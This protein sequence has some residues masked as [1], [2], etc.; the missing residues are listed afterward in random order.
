MKKLLAM[1]LLS[2]GFLAGCNA[3]IPAYNDPHA[4]LQVS[5]ADTGLQWKT[6]VGNVQTERVAGSGQ[7]KVS[8]QLYNTTNDDLTVDFKYWFTDKAGVQVEDNS[9]LGWVHKR[10]APRGYET[11]SF[12]SMTPA[13]E[14]FRVQIRPG[15]R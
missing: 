5:I 2:V 15:D 14:D 9:G 4:P 13:A 1:G 10:L 3:P 11:V 7:L 8:L 12:M 6:R